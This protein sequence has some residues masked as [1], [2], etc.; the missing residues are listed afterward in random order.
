VY[1]D[2]YARWANEIGCHHLPYNK[3]HCVA[4]GIV[5]GWVV[6]PDH[7]EF[8][9]PSAWGPSRAFHLDTDDPDEAAAAFERGREYVRTGQLGEVP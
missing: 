5:L 2:R 9:A 8:Q 7:P 4:A 1:E 6:D 3:K